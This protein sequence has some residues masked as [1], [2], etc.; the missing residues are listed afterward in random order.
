MST[1]DTMIAWN[2]RPWAWRFR[3]LRNGVRGV[4]IG[5][6]MIVTEVEQ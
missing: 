6:L 3:L 1:R 5:P 2:W 4:W